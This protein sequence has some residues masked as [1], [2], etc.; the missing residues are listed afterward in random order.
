[1]AS[2]IQIIKMTKSGIKILRKV[3]NH[4]FGQLKLK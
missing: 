1:M 4:D 2:K 3:E